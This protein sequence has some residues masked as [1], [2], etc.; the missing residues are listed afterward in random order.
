ALFCLLVWIK[1]LNMVRIIGV[2]RAGGDNQFCLITDTIVMWGIGLPV[3]AVCVF[4]WPQSFFILYCLMFL[5]DALKFVPVWRRIYRRRWLTN[6][7][8]AHP[9][10]EIH[11]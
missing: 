6:L 7:T 11:V 5:E 3:F 4:I 1:V 2:L 10:G 9:R 8:T